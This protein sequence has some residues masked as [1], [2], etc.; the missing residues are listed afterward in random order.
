MFKRR[1]RDRVGERRRRRKS[2]RKDDLEM[3]GCGSLDA[4]VYR[5]IPAL[6]PQK[7]RKKL[8]KPTI[9]KETNKARKRSINRCAQRSL[10][11]R[12]E[13]EAR[14]DL[15]SEMGITYCGAPPVPLRIEKGDYRR[16][17]M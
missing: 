10:D 6:Y 5:P 11:S 4:E 14:G 9:T 17:V 2:R 7:A 16:H 3:D 1:R 12:D 13:E 8:I 15:R